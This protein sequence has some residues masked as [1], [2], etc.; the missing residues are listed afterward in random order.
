MFS[1]EGSFFHREVIS[2]SWAN[3]VGV[4][5]ILIRTSGRFDSSGKYFVLINHLRS[6]VGRY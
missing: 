3:F 4:T 2:L 1:V 6:E 5:V